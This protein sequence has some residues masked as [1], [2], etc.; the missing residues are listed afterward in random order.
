MLLLVNR[1]IH[2]SL[3]REYFILEYGR[4]IFLFDFKSEIS[5]LLANTNNLALY[6]NK[7]AFRK[8]LC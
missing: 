2:K 3:E 6:K 1:Y 7:W 8:T 5:K 4:E